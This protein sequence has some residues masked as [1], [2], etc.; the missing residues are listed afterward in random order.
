M[1]PFADTEFEAAACAFPR[2]RKCNQECTDCCSRYTD[3]IERFRKI[4]SSSATE[5]YLSKNTHLQLEYSAR[6]L[7]NTGPRILVEAKTE[8]ITPEYKPN[9]RPGVMSGSITTVKE[10]MPEAPSPWRARKTILTLLIPAV[11]GSWTFQLWVRIQYSFTM[12]CA[13]PQSPENKANM[14]RQPLE[15]V[16]RQKISLNPARSSRNPTHEFNIRA[17]GGVTR[18]CLSPL[19][20][21]KY[22]V[23]IHE[24]RKRA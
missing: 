14:A 7:P 17:A 6:A 10:K 5:T 15:M 24:N 1:L 4:V 20:V 18:W 21:T 13:A 2:H 8:L 9:Q 3:E 19:K 22:A 11:Y 23:T 12:D 16:N